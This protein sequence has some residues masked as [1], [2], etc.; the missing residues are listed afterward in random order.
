MNMYNSDDYKRHIN[1]KIKLSNTKRRP[2]YFK[3]I[4]CMFIKKSES[5]KH[6]YRYEKMVSQFQVGQSVCRHL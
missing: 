4:I 3:P 6:D 5:V 1:N 2:K